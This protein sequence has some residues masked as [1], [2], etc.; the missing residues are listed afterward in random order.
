M[1]NKLGIETFVTGQCAK[2]K[3]IGVLSLEE[4]ALSSS[5]HQS[6]RGHCGRV[7]RKDVRAWGLGWEQ[8][9][10]ESCAWQGWCAHQFIAV[11]V[12]CIGPAQ[13]QA[14]QSPSMDAGGAPPLAKD[15]LS[16]VGCWG[17]DSQ[18]SLG[19]YLLVGCPYPGGWFYRYLHVVSTHWTQGTY[20]NNKNR[21]FSQEE[22]WSMDLGEVEIGSMRWIKSKHIVY[23]YEIFKE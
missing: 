11:V 15:L 3:W 1:Y 5:P 8:W 4:W 18:F 12:P 19:T 21:S 14:N 17:W 10:S 13:I 6:F 2:N 22:D 9:N 7:G 23:I 20:N 16:T